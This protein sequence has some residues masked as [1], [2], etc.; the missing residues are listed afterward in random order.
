MAGHNSSDAHSSLLDVGLYL[1]MH[2]YNWYWVGFAC[3][4][5]A[6]F[7]TVL[8][9]LTVSPPLAPAISSRRICARRKLTAYLLRATHRDHEVSA[10]STRLRPSS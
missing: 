2:G 7:V 1:T 8:L 5:S 10:S 4:L 3:M 9:D 6:L